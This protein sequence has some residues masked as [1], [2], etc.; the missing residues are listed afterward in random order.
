MP[1]S[2]TINKE[3]NGEILILRI[4]GQL[5]VNTSPTAESKIFD[6]IHEGHHKVLFDLSGLEFP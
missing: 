4:S 5:D 2:V 6:F 1:G 3:F